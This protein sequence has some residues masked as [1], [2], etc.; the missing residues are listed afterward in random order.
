MLASVPS[1]LARWLL[2]AVAVAAAAVAL[3]AAVGY[4]VAPG[5]AKSKLEEILS[6]ELARATTIERVEVRPFALAATVHGIA[7]REPDGPSHA[8]TVESVDADVSMASLKAFAPVLDALK[9]VRPHLRIAR[10]DANRYSVSD[11]IEKWSAPSG[12]PPAKYSLNN[13]E[14]RDGRIDFDDRPVQ[15]THAVAGLGIGP[16]ASV[17]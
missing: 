16:L 10:L 17:P 11:L 9:V 7:V 8:L 1:R 12:K 3:Y 5:I 14:I 13:I 4:W 15:R 2:V 6:R